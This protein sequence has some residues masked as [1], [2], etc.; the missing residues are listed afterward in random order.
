M[1][2]LFLLCA[3]AAGCFLAGCSRPHEA[4]RDQLL[5]KDPD[6]KNEPEFADPAMKEAERQ[7]T[8]LPSN[9]QSTAEVITAA[10]KVKGFGFIE[11]AEF[12]HEGR[13][14]FAVWY[15]PFS[16]RGDCFAHAYYY[17][18]DKG[19]W[20]RFLGRLV[21]SGGNLSVELPTREE[22]ILFRD[23]RGEVVVRESIAGRSQK[24]R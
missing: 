6:A 22:V 8:S 17:D 10:E 7:L 14:I 4:A 3:V 23:T 1:R 15:C 12:R 9:A 5:A 19:R 2:R 21:P 16:G 11:T 24:L 20:V 13:R 18:H